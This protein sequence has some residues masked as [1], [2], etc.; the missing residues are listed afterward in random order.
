MR[1]PPR[2]GAPAMR[3][4]SRCRS[5]RR[6]RSSAR[7]RWAT[8]RGGSLRRRRSDCSRPSVTRR[9]SRSRTPASSLSGPRARARSPCSPGPT[10]RARAGGSA[11][12]AGAERELAP[13]LDRGRLLTLI[14]ERATRLFSAPGVIY[15]AD[16]GGMLVPR[17]W[18]QGGGFGNMSLALGQGVVGA[19]AEQRRGLIENDYPASRFA[20]SKWVELGVRRAMAF[21]LSVQDRL[22]GVVAMNRAGADAVPFSDDDLAVL[23]SFAARAA[24]ALENARLYEQNRR[25]VEELSGLLELSRTVTGQLDRATLLEAIRAQV[26]R[27]L[28]ADNMA[29]VLHDDE[30]GDLEVV[31]RTLDGAID[32]RAPIRYPSRSVGLMSVVLELGEA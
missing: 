32:M 12:L 9:R 21:P 28:D 15:L 23:E 13:E 8:R 7:C 20:L 6:A 31:L 3:P 19:C 2:C 25:Q 11:A 17:A 4:C 26:G 10:A 24:I 16:A 14:I 18:T 1:S 22:L 5:G 27:V 30:R 29:I